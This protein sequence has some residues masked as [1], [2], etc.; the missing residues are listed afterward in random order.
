MSTLLASSNDVSGIHSTV[1]ISTLLLLSPYGKF[2]PCIASLQ[3][4]QVVDGSWPG[5]IQCTQAE[6]N[7]K[8]I[9]DT[10]SIKKTQYMCIY[11]YVMYIRI[12]TPNR[13][14][15][16]CYHSVLFERFGVF[17]LARAIQS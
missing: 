2:F 10:Q 12:T 17:V 13:L 6:Q 5:V 7:E 14:D 11:I 9:K 8:H 4:S 16:A 3:I 1:Q 15:A